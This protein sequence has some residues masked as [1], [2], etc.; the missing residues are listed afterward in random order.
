MLSVISQEIPTPNPLPTAGTDSITITSPYWGLHHGPQAA[1]LAGKGGY[2]FQGG[3]FGSSR[4]NTAPDGC[5]QCH[6]R[7]SINLSAGGHTFNGSFINGSTKTYNLAA[8]TVCHNGQ[9]SITAAK[10]NTSEAAIDALVTQLYNKLVA[11]QILNASGGLNIT[12]GKLKLPNDQAGALLN[13]LF[14]TS[15]NS[16]GLHNWQYATDLLNASINILP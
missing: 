8:C 12:N 7:A 16:H 10:V 3:T 4:H 13:Y 6:M 15:D 5:V 1:L 2:E 14:I 9:Y 11:D